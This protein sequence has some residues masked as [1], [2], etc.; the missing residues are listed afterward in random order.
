MQFINIKNYLKNYL[1]VSL[2][3]LFY[4]SIYKNKITSILGITSKLGLHRE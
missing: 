1:Y 4:L 3:Q 2:L